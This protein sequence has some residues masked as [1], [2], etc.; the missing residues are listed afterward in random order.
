MKLN[1]TKKKSFGWATW[2]LYNEK[3]GKNQMHSIVELN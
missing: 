3:E 2:H 1:T